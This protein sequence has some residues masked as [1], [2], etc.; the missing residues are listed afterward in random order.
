MIKWATQKTILGGDVGVRF[1]LS[2]TVQ[3]DFAAEYLSGSGNL[4]D[5]DKNETEVDSCSVNLRAGLSAKF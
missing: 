4:T 1:F 5:I 2:S 3:F